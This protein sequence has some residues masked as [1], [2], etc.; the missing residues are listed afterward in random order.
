MPLYAWRY[1]IGARLQAA[2]H[3]VQRHDV[4]WRISEDLPICPG[5]ITCETCNLTIWCRAHDPWWT[6]DRTEHQV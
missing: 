6:P 5:D 3:A 4:R 2:W 1:A